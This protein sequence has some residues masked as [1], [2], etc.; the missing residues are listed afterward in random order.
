MALK[1]AEP[2]EV[3]DVR[4]LGTKLRAAVTHSLLKT[5]HLQLMRV[6][7]PQ[8]QSL[9]EHRVGGDISVQCLEG[10][11]L[12]TTPSRSCQLEAGDLVVLPGGEPHAVRALRDTSLLVSVLLHA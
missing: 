1:H 9:P 10:Q 3:I 11:A 5:A 8:G 7:L 4:P 2:M 12:V 6:V